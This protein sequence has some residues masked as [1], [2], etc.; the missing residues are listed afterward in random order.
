LTLTKDDDPIDQAYQIGAD[1]QS[2]SYASFT[3]TTSI[4][5]EDNDIVYVLVVTAQNGQSTDFV[6]FDSATRTIQWFTED[7]Q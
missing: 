7:S 6:T 1:A 4:S 5:C 3:E 2:V